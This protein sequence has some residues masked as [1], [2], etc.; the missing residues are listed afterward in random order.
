M[1]SS[2]NKVCHY[3]SEE[4]NDKTLEIYRNC[5]REKDKCEKNQQPKIKTINCCFPENEEYCRL[6]KDHPQKGETM[7]PCAEKPGSVLGTAAEK[8][9]GVAGLAGS[10][11]TGAA[12]L[13][14]QGV[15]RIFNLRG[16]KKSRRNKRSN[17]KSRRRR[18]RK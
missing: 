10:A 1:S 8:I 2:C 9:V 12:S 15:N 16:G 7:I 6:F 11:V 17:K 4:K 3:P 14:G 18:H 13:V 5:V